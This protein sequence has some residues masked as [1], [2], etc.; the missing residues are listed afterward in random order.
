MREDRTAKRSRRGAGGRGKVTATRASGGEGRQADEEATVAS[1]V[2]GTRW[3]MRRRRTRRRVSLATSRPRR[4]SRAARRSAIRHGHADLRRPAQVFPPV[5][6]PL[7]CA[8]RVLPERRNGIFSFSGP[9]AAP[10]GPSPLGEARLR[11]LHVFARASLS[12]FPLARRRL[13]VSQS[14]IRSRA[15]SLAVPRFFPPPRPFLPAAV[16][17]AASHAGAPATVTAQ[18]P[19]RRRRSTFA[20]FERCSRCARACTRA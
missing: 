12:A 10:W 5:L 3:R 19:C 16:A 7:W 15:R 8:F 4:I 14:R 11:S 2:E 13:R 17:L 20:T 9:A 1:G 6:E 18:G